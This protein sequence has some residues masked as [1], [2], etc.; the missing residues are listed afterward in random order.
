VIAPIHD[1]PVGCVT[2]VQIA[3]GPVSPPPFIN[4]F[5][6]YIS[7]VESTKILG[8]LKRPELFQQSFHHVY[9]NTKYFSIC[10]EIVRQWIRKENFK[11]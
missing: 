2:L 7:V 5:M 6:F 9:C 11:Y 10:Q 1:H 4:M 3:Q 8:L